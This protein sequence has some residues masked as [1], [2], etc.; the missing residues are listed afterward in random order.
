MGIPYVWAVHESVRPR[1]FWSEAYGATGYDPAIRSLGL[2]ALRRADRVIFE[3]AAT[4]QLYAGEVSADR[5]V[6]VPYGVDVAA[7]DRYIEAHDRDSMRR[8]D[9]FSSEDVVLVIVGTIEPRKAQA[10]SMLAF[11]ALADRFPHA[12][13]VLVGDHPSPY[14]TAVHELLARL[15]LEDRIELVHVTSD[16]Y[17]WYMVA[18]AV[19]SA[20]DF[21]SMPRSLIEA[22]AFG[23]VIL[24]CDVFGIPEL[25]TDGETGLLMPA[26][27][28]SGLISG[29]DRLLSLASCQREAIGE[30]AR[31]SV[32][33]HH[34]ARGY[35]DRYRGILD[36]LV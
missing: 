15:R 36:E 29:I 21:E 12:K 4:L 8:R 18:D 32:S 35:V 6:V 17:Y 28:L 24:S 25:I 10:A 30:A 9:G 1:A 26:R 11:A 33:K 2:E 3:A 34:D 14:S 16:V 20:S 7:I 27:D 23:R 19:V 31:T 22:M 13:L 5:L